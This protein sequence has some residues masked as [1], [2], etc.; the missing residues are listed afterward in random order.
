MNLLRLFI[1]CA[2]LFVSNTYA[3]R[4]TDAKRP[5]VLFIAVDDLNDW[6]GLLHGNKQVIS[7]N[8]DKLASD[9]VLFTN[10]HTP[11]AVCIA[12]RN[13]LLSGL[14]PTT[15]GWYSVNKDMKAMRKSYPQVMAGKKM[16]PHYFSDNGYNTYCAGKIFHTGSS[17][18]DFI[19][20]SLWDEILPTYSRFVTE[21]DW[22]TADGYKG[23]D[24][25]PFPKNRSQLSVHY[26][27]KIKGGHSLCGG[28]LDKEDIPGGKMYDELIAKYAI[29]KLEEKHED[30]FFLSIGFIR[31]HV[32][33][34]APRKYFDLYDKNQIKLPHV[35]ND[36]MADIPLIGKAI[37]YNYGVPEM[38]DYHAVMGLG[39]DY[40][41][42][43]VYSYLACVSFVD[44]QIGRVL[45]TLENSEYA[46]NTIIVLWSDHGQSLGEKRDFRKMSLWEEST[47]VPLC[48]VAPGKTKGKACAKPVSLMD[49]YPT[50]ID[51]CNL[52]E[53]KHLDG[54]SITPLICN[55]KQEWPMPVITNWRYKNYSVRTENY[56]YIQYRD[57][58]EE[59]YDHTKDKGE[60]YNLIEEPQ[61]QNIIQYLRK[62]IPSDVALPVGAKDWDGDEIESTIKTWMQNDSIPQWLN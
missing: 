59:F 11:M 23:P 55:P 43:L 62:H 19:T 16:L 9:G 52:P 13:A 7:P 39:E 5:N 22:V 38:G 47:R 28:P 33:Y 57:G 35:P 41:R 18:Y 50:L 30:P 46:D 61:Y 56:R 36:E 20:D 34:T 3:Q 40:W 42:H 12:S 44:D 2:I 60:H 10:A 31:P 21:E 53:Q 51:L 27:D 37:A 4:K 14:H 32:P 25:F 45:T 58:S 48:I 29:E 54:N 1:L 8:L 6:T 24:Y 49:I 17:D 26:G 15:T